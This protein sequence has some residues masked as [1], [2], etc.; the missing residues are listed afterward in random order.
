MI[1]QLSISARF[2]PD[3]TGPTD[4]TDEASYYWVIN[5]LLKENNTV[6]NAQYT[7]TPNS[8]ITTP[9]ITDNSGP[10]YLSF[11]ISITMVKQ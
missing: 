1:Q 11:N 10:T 2:H 4:T 5:P 9:I 6:L 8:Y 7:D 3:L